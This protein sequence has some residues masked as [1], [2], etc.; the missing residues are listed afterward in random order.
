M[1]IR[2]SSHPG[3]QRVALYQESAV[4]RHYPGKAE[5]LFDRLSEVGFLYGGERP[6]ADQIF[7]VQGSDEGG[8]WVRGFLKGLGEL[9]FPVD[10]KLSLIHILCD[11]I[12]DGVL[13]AILRDDP[14][15][16][17]ACEALSTTC[18][19]YTS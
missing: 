7:G 14:T 13:D 18:L 6:D 5:G 12:S 9:L 3:N 16:R 11:Q 2:D 4:H 15:A 19:L 1:C 17:V 10:V 8:V